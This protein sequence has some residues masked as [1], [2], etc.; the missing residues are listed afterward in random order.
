M[1]HTF[2]VEKE[3]ISV[4]SDS[5]NLPCKLYIAFYRSY[6]L[7]NFLYQPNPFLFTLACVTT[8]SLTFVCLVLHPGRA[9]DWSL[10]FLPNSLKFA[11]CFWNHFVL[12]NKANDL[13]S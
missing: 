9:G 7:G 8:I 10:F 12:Y 11:C 5:V 2:R 1:P 6:T 13:L 3:S 4:C